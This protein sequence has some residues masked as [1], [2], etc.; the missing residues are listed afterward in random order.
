MKCPYCGGAESYQLATGQHRCKEC[1]RKFSPRRLKL[2]AYIQRCFCEELPATLCAARHHLHFLTV[3]R[4]YHNFRHQIA[5]FMEGDF[6]ARKRT[7]AYDEYLYLPRSR[8]HLKEA[9]FDGYNFLTFNYDGKIYNLLLPDL[10]RFKPAFLED[11]LEELYAKEFERF[12]R[13]SHIASSH[14]PLIEEFWEYFEDFIPKFRG[15]KRENFVYYLKEAEFRFNFDCT[16]LQKI[17]NF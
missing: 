3:Q 4:R 12:L 5:A 15:F 10:A 16:F 11:G 17:V 8:R 2:E 9:I 6:L 1:R 14:D 7:I 13:R